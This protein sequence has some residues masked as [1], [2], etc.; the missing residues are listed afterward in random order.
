MHPADV[1]VGRYC[2]NDRGTI[3]YAQ[4]G[5]VPNGKEVQANVRG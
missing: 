2:D 5:K 4:Q 1:L 3:R